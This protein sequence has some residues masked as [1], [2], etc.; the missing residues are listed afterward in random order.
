M[1]SRDTHQK[2]PQATETASTWTFLSNHAHVLICLAADPEQRLRDVAVRVGITERAVQKI[3]DALEAEGLL[4]RERV[5][6]R[7][8]YGLHLD[9]PLR[10]P[11]EAHRSVREL[12]E[13]VTQT[14]VGNSPI[15]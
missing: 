1:L 12:I 10:H 4:S 9:Q 8:R 2:S 13:L 6:R 14:S 7:N 3:I 5:G 11:L 15:A